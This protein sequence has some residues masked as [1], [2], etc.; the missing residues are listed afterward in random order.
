[1]HRDGKLHRRTAHIRTWLR[2][3]SVVVLTNVRRLD[4]TVPFVTSRFGT[5][6]H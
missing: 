6:G 3:E 1:M 2:S 5:G 4:R